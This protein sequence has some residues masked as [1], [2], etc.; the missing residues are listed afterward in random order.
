MI[1]ISDKQNCCGC[2]ACAQKCPKHC[3]TMQQDKEGF[4]Y[5]IIDTVTCIDCGLCENVCPIINSYEK[6]S[7]L[8]TYAA[9]N[10][11]DEIRL[12]SSSG[13]IFTLLAEK[14]IDDGGVVFGARFDENW[15]VVIDYTETKD[16][17]AAFRGSKYVQASTLNTYTQ[18]EDFLK[19]G[20]KV[21]YTGTPCQIAGLKHF[22]RKD[23]DNLLTVDFVCHGAPS[24]K[25]W[26]CYLKE[27]V[28]TLTNARESSVCQKNIGWQLAP[29]QII[30]KKHE[31][32]LTL[33]IPHDQNDYMKA[34]INDMILRPSCYMC[35]TKECNSHSDITIADFWGVKKV[36]PEMYDNKG[37]SLVLIHTF[38]G[39]SYY[40]KIDVISKETVFE[41]GCRGN[42]A[43]YSSAKPHFR[44]DLFFIELQSS[45][46]IVA[47]IQKML[48]PTIQMVC[49]ARLAAII[50]IPMKIV[51]K[52]IF[53]IGTNGKETTMVI[54]DKDED[55][56]NIKQFLALLNGRTLNLHSI[57]FRNKTHGWSSYYITIGFNLQPKI[58]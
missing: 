35:A 28:G 45:E 11:N 38:K 13:G 43:I 51:K 55:I 1:I 36:I 46:S 9:I 53:L 50:G 26:E 37:T 27:I 49:S 33:S 20:R 8:H 2:A 22:L 21:M 5:P 6:Q 14:I 39:D 3:I 7:P 18:C 42:P 4:F 54:P 16:G 48:K 56:I 31:D 34:F 10:K 57:N 58:V 29:F 17:I 47:L 24:P 15:Q 19:I 52:I 40:K 12:K 25:V 41:D 32:T 30:Y 23:Y 44:R